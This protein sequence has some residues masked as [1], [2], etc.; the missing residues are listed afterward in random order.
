MTHFLLYSVD[1]FDET[2]STVIFQQ[3]SG[4]GSTLCSGVEIFNDGVQDGNEF[5]FIAILNQN[6]NPDL[7]IDEDRMLKTVTILDGNC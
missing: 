3:G 2:P 6:Q 1:D 5:F 7:V 4:P